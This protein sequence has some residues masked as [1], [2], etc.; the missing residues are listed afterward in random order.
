MNNGFFDDESTSL[1]TECAGAVSDAEDKTYE[2]QEQDNCDE[3]DADEYYELPM[4]RRSILWSAL[5]VF[6]A[7]L[8]VLFC[9]I[10]IA[11]IILSVC[12]IVC[13]I[14]SSHRLGFFDKMSL[15]GL[16]VGIFGGV[17]GIFAMVID[18][19]GALDGL[20]MW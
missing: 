20:L 13:S 11:G 6:L 10:Y 9:S 5:S 1:P 16:I 14:I 2:A 15:F 8:S 7:V 19:T 17:F 3:S 18:L 4:G 12:A